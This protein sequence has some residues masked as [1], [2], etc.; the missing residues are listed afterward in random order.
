VPGVVPGSSGAERINVAG[1]LL[2]VASLAVFSSSVAQLAGRSGSEMLKAA[3]VAGGALA[4]TSLAASATAAAALTSVPGRDEDQASH[5]TAFCFCGRASARRWPG[6]TAGRTGTGRPTHRG[7]TP[8]GIAALA[9]AAV[10]ALA[11]LMLA[12]PRAALVIPAG[13]FLAS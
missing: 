1:Q 5:Y 10:D 7:A 9:A 13:R 12:L 6:A 4:S 3:A 11:P 2:S 8:M